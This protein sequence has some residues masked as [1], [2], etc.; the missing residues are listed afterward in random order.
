VQVLQLRGAVLG[1][2]RV[3]A[4]P[5]IF[6]QWFGVPPAAGRVAALL[7]DACGQLVTREQIMRGAGITANSVHLNI[8]R[9]RAAMEPGAIE[10]SPRKGFRLAEA[11]VEDCAQAMADAYTRAAA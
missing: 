1:V 10:C 11:G 6:S 2:E 5:A 4:R 8:Q 3:T 9:L 7:Y